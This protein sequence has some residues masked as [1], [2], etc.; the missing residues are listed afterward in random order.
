MDAAKATVKGVVS[1]AAATAGAV[2]VGAFATGV[3]GL[4]AAPVLATGIVAVVA[5]LFVSNRIDKSINLTNEIKTKANSFIKGCGDF[6][7]GM[8]GWKQWT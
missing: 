8:K 3:L 4:T 7:K 6:V 5:A 2:A 1:T